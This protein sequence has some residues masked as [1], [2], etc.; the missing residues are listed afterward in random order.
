MPADVHLLVGFPGTGKY[1]VAKALVAELERRGQVTKLVDSHYV[2]NP[3]FGL[4]NQD[5]HTPL[6]AGVWP[7]IERVRVALLETIEEL[8]P[9]DY[10]FVFTNF[11]TDREAAL[12]HVVD[13]LARL[14]RIA[15]ARGGRLRVTRLTCD[16]E[17]LCR[18]IVR[19]DRKQRLKMTSAEGGR[20][21]ASGDLDLFT[22]IDGSALT[23]DITE[24]QPHAA[25]ERI[26]QH[27]G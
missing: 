20:A 7:I 3:V 4:V 8:S 22:P 12:P 15:A 24:L 14:E 27:A 26:L 19:P 13:Y 9:L 16:V 18:R 2:N 21:L 5:G 11:I 6:P 10:A 25:A 1:T 17:E 23:L